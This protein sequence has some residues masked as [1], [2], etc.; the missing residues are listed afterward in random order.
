MSA[1][2][3]AFL[4][5]LPRSGSTL[6]QRMVGAHPAV[7][8]TAEPWLLLPLLSARAPDG[9][10][11]RYNH[12]VAREA[13]QAFS[14]RMSDGP[15]GLAEET[16]RYALRMY[17]RAAEPQ[18]EVFLDKT[19]RYGLYM[20]ELLR[21]FP[22]ASM[23]VLWRNPLS[24]LASLSRSFDRGQWKPHHHIV[25]LYDLLDSLIRAVDANPARFHRLAYEDLISDPEKS[26]RGVLAHLELQWDDRVTRGFAATDV[27]GP[28][29]DLSVADSLATLRTVSSTGADRWQ[30]VLASPLRRRWAARYVDWIGS[31]RL[32]VM[33]YD[34]DAL[35][36]DLAT[37]PARWSTVPADVY[38]ATKGVVWRIV[39]PQILRDKWAQRHMRERITSHG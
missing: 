17:A 6:L 23:I 24:V 35:L 33:G 36:K 30:D 27:S 39:E 34:R 1:V 3:P 21:A 14:E 9:V 4:L 13:M 26:L 22:D 18:A 19:P 37:T 15:R 32:T 5:S 8:T 10:Y 31:D 11:T 20:E 28:V 12:R 2:R 29:G 25:D 7:S 16:R 38:N